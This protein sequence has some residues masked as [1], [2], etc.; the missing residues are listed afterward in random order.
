[1]HI[2]WALKVGL[3][4]VTFAQHSPNVG[5]CSAVAG[6]SCNGFGGVEA[7]PILPEVGC[8]SVW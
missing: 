8:S 6:L 4:H 7:G 2:Q 5:S 1:M 3:K